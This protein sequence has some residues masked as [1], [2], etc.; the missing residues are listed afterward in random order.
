MIQ[1]ILDE[2]LDTSLQP[3]VNP[4]YTIRDNNGRTIEDDVQIDL[5]TPVVQNPTPLNRATLNN[6]LGDLYTQD[7][8]NIPTII[9]DNSATIV[10]QEDLFSENTG[11]WKA[12]QTYTKY[13]SSKGYIVEGNQASSGN[14][15]YDAFNETLGSPWIAKS[16][17]TAI[18]T[19][20]CPTLIKITKM[21]VSFLYHSGGTIEGS[22]NGT[23][24]INLYNI[25]ADM[26]TL[27]T[28][29]LQN[30]NYYKYYRLKLSAEANNTKGIYVYLFDGVEYETDYLFELDLPLTS[31]EVGKKLNLKGISYGGVDVFE[32]PYININNLGAVQIMGTIKN[33][34][35]YNL[36]F[37]GLVWLSEVTN[38]GVDS[39]AIIITESG[40]YDV[41]AD[42]QYKVIAI[43]GGGGGAVDY[44]RYFEEYNRPYGGGAGGKI[45]DVFIPTSNKVD[46]VIGSAG[47]NGT[48]SYSYSNSEGA[49]G[50]K[51]GDTTI[52]K[53]IAY[54]GG[55]AGSHG[56]SQSASS[57]FVG[58]G[59]SFSGGSGVKGEDG[60]S[61]YNNTAYSSYYGTGGEGWY[62]NGEYY[63]RGGTFDVDYRYDLIQQIKPTQGIVILYP[64]I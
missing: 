35:Y 26:T 29:T 38:L 4:R 16:V 40:T 10:K 58:E 37:D 32:N 9:H 14:P 51:G 36:V 45:E 52:G 55:G 21:E 13:Q 25:T 22:A 56:T 28:V 33:N 61:S 53:F 3:D 8:Y 46:V 5:K 47:T 23:E 54:G 34:K 11:G 1:E 62:V 12:I 31:Y 7:R 17:D 19:V 48:N 43:G 60:K 27:Q 6:M 42:V 64:L 59:G 18:L 49:Y 30:T 50:T 41:D 24:W 63:G 20:T 39:G 2:V 44:D 57:S 15:V